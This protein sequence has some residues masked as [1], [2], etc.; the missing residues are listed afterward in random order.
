[1]TYLFFVSMITVC[2]L[3]TR[4]LHHPNAFL[5]RGNAKDNIP[6]KIR[7]FFFAFFHFFV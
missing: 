2:K 4:K 3:E 6:Q 7:Y 1:M 5:Q